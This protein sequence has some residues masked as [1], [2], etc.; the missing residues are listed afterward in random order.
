[1]KYALEYYTR[2][3]NRRAIN[4]YINPIKC[5]VQQHLSATVVTKEV[6]LGYSLGLGYAVQIFMSVDCSKILSVRV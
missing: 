6:L 3:I 5:K 1:M 4:K 2:K